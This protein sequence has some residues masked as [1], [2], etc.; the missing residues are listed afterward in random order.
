[1]ATIQDNTV[2]SV[3]QMINASELSFLGNP[4]AKKRILIVGNSIT[5]HGPKADIGWN[6]DWGMAASAPEKDYVHRLYAMLQEDGQDVYMRIRQ[7]AHWEGNFD[8]EDILSRYDE[9][10]EFDADIVVFRL[11]ENVRTQ[12]NLAWRNAVETFSS[13][14]CPTGKILFVTCFWENPFIDDEVKAVAEKRGDVCLDGYLSYDEN[15][16]AL[17]KFAHDGVAIHPS[18]EGMEEIAKLIFKGI[19][20]LA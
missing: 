2:S 20:D 10:R 3:N 8:K 5:R 17:G 15:N 7:C 14:I 18:D 4:N 13:H 1:M 12:D 9:E 6:F 19:K 11:G 16:M